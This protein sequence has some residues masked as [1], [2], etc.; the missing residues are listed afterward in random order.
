M[1]FRQ[2]IS[3][4]L[5]LALALYAAPECAGETSSYTASSET[6]QSVSSTQLSEVEKQIKSHDRLIFLELEKLAEFNVT[7]QQNV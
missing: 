1:R 7:Y 4:S 5:L 6:A 2:Q 3:L